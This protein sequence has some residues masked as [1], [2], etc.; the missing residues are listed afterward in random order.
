MI[1]ISL[2]GKMKKAKRRSDSPNLR[3]I[4]V[5]RKTA[6][7]GK[8]KQIKARTRLSLRIKS[9]LLGIKTVSFLAF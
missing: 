7:G 8:N 6:K 3:L 1:L 4:P 9:S 2:P 5:L